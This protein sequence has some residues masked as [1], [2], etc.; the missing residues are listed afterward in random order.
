MISGIFGLSAFL[1]G[2]VVWVLQGWIAGLMAFLGLQFGVPVLAALLYW[3]PDPD[4][5]V[6]N[7]RFAARLGR[8]RTVAFW[9]TI[10]VAI[11]AALAFG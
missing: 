1:A 9:G 5:A 4:P 7:A 10:G 8:V 3:K 6:A 11:V 2:L